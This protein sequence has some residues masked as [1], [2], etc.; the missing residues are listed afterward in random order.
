M[1]DLEPA[2]TGHPAARRGGLAAVAGLARLAG[3]AGA[4]AGQGTRALTTR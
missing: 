1:A 4:P 3:L 2:A